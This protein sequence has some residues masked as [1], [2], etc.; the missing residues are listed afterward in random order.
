MARIFIS[1]RRAESESYAVALRD[2]LERRFGAG[3]VFLDQSSI[4]YGSHFPDAIAR[5]LAEAKVC[6][7]L[8]G[9]RWLTITDSDD[10]S[11][12]LRR[13]HDFVRREVSDALTAQKA[14]R[15]RLIPVL[16]Q[17][18][19]V[20]GVTDLPD[21][22]QEL[23]SLNGV[24]VASVAADAVR[25]ADII[26]RR[27]SVLEPAIVMAMAA[28]V[29]L[30]VR[31]AHRW[32]A[33]G[34]N[35]S[36]LH[37]G[38]VAVTRWFLQMAGNS[39]HYAIL[40]LGVL[41]AVRSRTG[42]RAAEMTRVVACV[43]LGVAAL[44]IACTPLLSSLPVNQGWSSVAYIAVWF[45]G[46]ALGSAI[47]IHLYAPTL[48]VSRLQWLRLGVTVVAAGCLGSVLQGLVV[49][50]ANTAAW[51]RNP[52]TVFWGPVLLGFVAAWQPEKSDR[53]LAPRPSV[54]WRIVVPVLLTM[55]AADS[56]AVTTSPWIVGRPQDA[57]PE[58]WRLID[59]KEV[60]NHAVFFGLVAAVMA[61]RINSAQREADA[62]V[63]PASAPR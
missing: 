30:A 27:H 56:F 48:R 45:A 2:E 20:P 12:R 8:I 28:G 60:W 14:G 47:G 37:E 17:D 58:S 23:S 49:E 41:L 44:T 22:L 25:L 10:G 63:N 1:Y 33:S 7:V 39:L 52:R 31:T 54:R 42:W 24:V 55:L 26:E 61:W 21:D 3:S 43:S 19:R 59:A 16:L 40:V 5:A 18:A 34:T 62:P 6:L 35:L 53:S 38:S 29:G 9:Q 46:A 4:D 51:M 11:P 15:L 13:E 50:T 36:G 32:V 57:S